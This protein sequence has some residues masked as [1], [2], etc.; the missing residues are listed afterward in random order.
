MPDDV[1][2]DLADLVEDLL[3][4]DPKE[5]PP[6]AQSVALRL[7]LADHEMTGLALGLAQAVYGESR[8]EDVNG[9]TADMPPQQP[10]ATVAVISP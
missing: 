7:G 9:T 5:R 3:A 1:P 10:T 6:N 8:L 2:K 4:K